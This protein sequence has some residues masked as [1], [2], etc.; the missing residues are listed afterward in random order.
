MYKAQCL[1]CGAVQWVRC[2]EEDHTTGSFEC[3]DPDQDE[4]EGGC[5]AV[6]GLFYFDDLCDH[7]E[8]DYVD[9]DH[10]YEE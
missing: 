2:I 4:W 1:K 5:V 9:F 6:D 7:E 3:A 8:F 10:H